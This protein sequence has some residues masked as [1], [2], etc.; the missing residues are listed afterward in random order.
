MLDRKEHGVG[1]GGREVRSKQSPKLQQINVP[2]ATHD[3]ES[4]I[5]ECGDV[6]GD[7]PNFHCLVSSDCMSKDTRMKKISNLR[8]RGLGPGGPCAIE[9]ISDGGTKPG[10]AVAEFE[11]GPRARNVDLTSLNFGDVNVYVRHRK[12]RGSLRT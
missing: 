9:M 1:G 10:S 11:V 5:F 4:C 2:M 7:G 12:E 8:P 3:L 6:E